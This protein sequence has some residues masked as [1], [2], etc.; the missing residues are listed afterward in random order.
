MLSRTL[1]PVPIGSKPLKFKRFPMLPGGLWFLVVLS[2]NR[3]AL[4]KIHRKFIPRRPKCIVC[5]ILSLIA[6]CA[7]AEEKRTRGQIVHNSQ[8]SGTFDLKRIDQRRLKR[9]L[10][11]G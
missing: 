2:T 6:R 7:I 10:V 3:Y 5:R 9:L 11:S 1:S 8:R 4:H